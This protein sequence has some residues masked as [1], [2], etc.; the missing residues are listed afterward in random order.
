M[1]IYIYTLYIYICV[2]WCQT[3]DI[4]ARKTPGLDMFIYDAALL[5]SWRFLLTSRSWTDSMVSMSEKKL[6]L[7]GKISESQLKNHEKSQL[8]NFAPTFGWF[9]WIFIDFQSCFLFSTPIDAKRI[10]LGSST[11]RSGR[12]WWAKKN[13]GCLIVFLTQP[14]LI[15]IQGLM[16]LVTSRKTDHKAVELMD[17]MG[18]GQD[19]SSY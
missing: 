6:F 12:C 3:S 4:I 14:G 11:N 19:G 17:L 13:L 2:V 8:Q 7:N 10:A 16:I 15:F 5:A 18:M 1:Y 9:S